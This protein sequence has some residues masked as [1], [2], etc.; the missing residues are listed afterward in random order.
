MQ[1]RKKLETTMKVEE[2]RAESEELQSAAQHERELEIQVRLHK[3]LNRRS[4]TTIHL[5]TLVT[6][7]EGEH[8]GGD[9]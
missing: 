8:E 4:V 9:C 3:I 6:E 1:M 5:T 7:D 2:A